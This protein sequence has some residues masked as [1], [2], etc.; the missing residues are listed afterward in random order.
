MGEPISIRI[1]L[2]VILLFAAAL[3]TCPTRG[4]A[5]PH[6]LRWEREASSI[7]L[8]AD[9][10]TVWK[11]RYGQDL[12]K[13]M[14]HPLALV[15]GTVLTWDSPPDHPWHHALWFSWKYLNHVNYWEADPKEPRRAGAKPA[16]GKSQEPR[17]GLTDWSDVR[18]T[19]RRNFG[20]GNRSGSVL[21]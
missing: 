2:C 1:P 9:G 3:S 17:G 7:A 20:A 8:L 5:P 15:D 11:F 21:P 18:I 16:A 13:P 19:P 4:A 6:Q 12:P 10:K 14:F